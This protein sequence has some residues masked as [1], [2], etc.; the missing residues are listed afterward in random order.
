MFGQT[1]TTI[2][3]SWPLRMSTSFTSASWKKTSG[4]YMP[5]WALPSRRHCRCSKWHGGWNS[6][7]WELDTVG[8]QTF[9]LLPWQSITHAY[10]FCCIFIRIEYRSW[11]ASIHDSVFI[12]YY[13]SFD[14]NMCVTSLFQIH[15]TYLACRHVNIV[16]QYVDRLYIF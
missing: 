3:R 16:N 15:K 8:V 7:E 9:Y 4:I 5:S 13:I 10:I 6:K 2:E 12:E 14:K 11:L 1:P